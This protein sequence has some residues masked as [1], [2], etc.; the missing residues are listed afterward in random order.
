[1]TRDK[2]LLKEKKKKIKEKEDAV[3]VLNKRPRKAK[4]LRRAKRLQRRQRNIPKILL[5]MK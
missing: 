1:M 5:K 4:N 2:K 3:K